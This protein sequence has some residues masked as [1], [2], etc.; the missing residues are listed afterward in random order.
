MPHS[1]DY[2]SSLMSGGFVQV[3]SVTDKGNLSNGTP[4]TIVAIELTAKALR[5]LETVQSN[6]TPNADARKSGARRLA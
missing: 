1:T 5:V 2:Y 6:P 4:D 3:T